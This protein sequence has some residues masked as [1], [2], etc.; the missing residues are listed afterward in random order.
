MSLDP[1]PDLDPPT[2]GEDEPLATV[3][4][5]EM[6]CYR[7]CPRE[8]HHRYVDLRRPLVDAHAL[9]FGRAIHLGLEAWWRTPRSAWRSPANAEGQADRL[10]AA[11]RAVDD[12]TDPTDRAKLQALLTGYHARWCD[13]PLETLAVE[14]P[15]TVRMADVELV[16][17]IDAIARHLPSGRLLLVEHKST[18]DDIT[19][20]SDYWDRLQA[21]DGQVSTYVL[22]AR[23]LGYEVDACLY[24]VIKKPSLRPTLKAPAGDPYRARLL[25]DIQEHP[26]AY[27]ARGEIV[28]L[29]SE[30]R[31][32]I[33]DLIPVASLISQHTYRNPDACIRFHRRC[34]YY[35]VCSGRGRISD[36]TVFRTA[37]RMHEELP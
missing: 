20:G 10:S 37:A 23:S 31:A 21:L 6:A 36:D 13:E 22:G 35:D 2:A 12:V 17:R 24:D 28:R 7:R 8:H 25:A 11:L 18:S 26:E 30:L 4:H 9:R 32:H 3:S 1:P 5:S 15:F 33:R 27:Y 29:D 34:D 16:G 14:A 19:M